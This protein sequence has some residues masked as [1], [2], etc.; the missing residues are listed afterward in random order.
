MGGLPEQIKLHVEMRA[1]PD[2]QS[3]M[4]L[5]RAF[6]WCVP[7]PA[8]ASPTRGARAP[9]R[10]GLPPPPSAL[11]APAAGALPLPAPGQG[12]APAALATR[13]FRRLSSAEQLERCRRGFA[14][15]AMSLF[16]AVTCAHACSTWTRTTTSM[17]I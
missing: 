9:Q 17:M 6:E 10:L 7:A 16:F 11:G 1:P 13:P 12:G 14:S 3:A 4:Y 8:A 2:L 15:T 5:V